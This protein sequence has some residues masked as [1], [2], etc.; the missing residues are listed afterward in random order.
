MSGEIYIICRLQSLSHRVTDKRVDTPLPCCGIED[1]RVCG[2]STSDS[3]EETLL[4]TLST[5]EWSRVLYRERLVCMPI[6]E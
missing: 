6:L 2:N 5:A 3:P 1:L 4:L